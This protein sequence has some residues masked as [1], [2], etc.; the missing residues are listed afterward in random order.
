[1]KHSFGGNG[2][3]SRKRFV[4]HGRKFR[5]S[6]LSQVGELYGSLKKEE[7]SSMQIHEVD[8]HDLPK[9]P[10]IKK[11]KR[12]VPKEE[13]E[14]IVF[15]TWLTRSNILFTA[16]ANGGYRNPFEALKFK[17]MG[18]SP[19]FPDICIPIPKGQ[20]HGLFIEMKR[21]DGGVVSPYQKEWL[22]SL[23]NYGYKAV[24]CHGFEQAIK[25]TEQY[26]SLS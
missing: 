13:R 10:I 3:S 5:Q 18:V 7:G 2:F 11:K 16:S 15:A 12:I 9:K 20:Y 22:E 8:K 19:G 1:M 4:E 14:Q 24:V 17:R 6:Y 26:L 21:R 25:E 23:N